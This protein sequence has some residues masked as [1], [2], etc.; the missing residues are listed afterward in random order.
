[1][2][3]YLLDHLTHE[4]MLDRRRAAETDALVRRHRPRRGRLTNLFA[5]LARHVPRIRPQ[6][7][8]PLERAP[9][10]TRRAITGE[11]H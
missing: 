10:T 9:R 2:H 8:S 7:A 5:G 6:P 11:A 1:M 4:R 3:P